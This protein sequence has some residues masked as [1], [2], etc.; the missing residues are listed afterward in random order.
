MRIDVV[1]GTRAAIGVALVLVGCRLLDDK[2]H[3][4]GTVVFENDCWLF[5]DTGEHTYVPMDLPAAFLLDSL[6]VQLVVEPY[7]GT[8]GSYCLYDMVE[9]V[10]AKKGW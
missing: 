8:L 4:K 3:L 10:S 5:R 6:Q 9:V 7:K 1:T 2:S